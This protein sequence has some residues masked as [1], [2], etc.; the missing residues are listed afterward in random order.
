MLMRQNINSDISK[1][2][3]TQNV[4]INKLIRVGVMYSKVYKKS[5]VCISLLRRWERERCVT[6]PNNGCEGDC[7]Y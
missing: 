3:P 4:L 5:D 7:V 1:D 6:S 2:L